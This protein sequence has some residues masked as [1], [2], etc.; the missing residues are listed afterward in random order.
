MMF[1]LNRGVFLVALS[2]AGLSLAAIAAPA[3]LASPVPQPQAISP[4]QAERVTGRNVTEVMA[5]ESRFILLPGNAWEERGRDGARFQ[6]VEQNRDDWSVYLID[7][8]RG[9]RLQ[10]DLHT[11]TISYADAGE[12]RMRPLYRVSDASAV[13]NGRNMN[14]AWTAGGQFFMTGPGR[15]EERGADGAAFRFAETNRDDWSVYLH[16]ASRGVSLAIDAH[17]RRVMYSDR[18]APQWRPLYDLT[19]VSAVGR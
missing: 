6:F 13:V 7:D 16:D 14:R 18:G 8:S 1:H 4:T 3:A 15:W 11:R 10:L 9:V 17:T 5:P 19:R 12:P 2:L